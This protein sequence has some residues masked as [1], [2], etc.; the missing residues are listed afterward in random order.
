MVGV[1]GA[2]VLEKASERSGQLKTICHNQRGEVVVDGEAKVRLW[3][4]M[5]EMPENIVTIGEVNTG[6]GTVL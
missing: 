2:G 3:R 4:L 6:D 5:V 1:V